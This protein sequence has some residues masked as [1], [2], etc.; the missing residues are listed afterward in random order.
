[1]D[2]KLKCKKI[3]EISPAYNE[4]Y[5]HKCWS[6]LAPF[7]ENLEV[8]VIKKGLDF[9]T[10]YQFAINYADLILAQLKDPC[11][12][13]SFHKASPGPYLRVSTEVFRPLI[14]LPKSTIAGEENLTHME[15]LVAKGENIILFANHQIEADPQVLYLMLEKNHLN[16]IKN[17]IFV[18][19]ARVLTDPVAAPF[20]RG[21]NLLSVFSKRYFQA[22]PEKVPEMREHNNNTIRIISQLLNEGGKSILIFP[23][24]GRDR[25]DANGVVQV[26]PFDP[27]STELLYLLGR[28]SKVETHFFPVALSTHDILPPPQ[29]LQVSLGE[30]RITNEAP[31]YLHF[32]KKIDMDNFPISD[33]K[34]RKKIKDIRAEYIWSLVRKMYD[35]FPR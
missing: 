29:D 31:V 23:A 5:P 18:A 7:L 32:G 2:K 6:L 8:V 34:D 11:K 4:L 33:T 1:M 22:H 14:N 19:G 12:F 28:R 26:S 21:F 27:Q 24:G 10:Y 35:Q 30:T 20:S 17:T 3:S 13:E 15:Q 16:L 9:D 25:P